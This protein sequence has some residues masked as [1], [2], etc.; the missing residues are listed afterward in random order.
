[1]GVC[2]L[3]IQNSKIPINYTDQYNNIFQKEKINKYS[4]KYLYTRAIA[5]VIIFPPKA[6]WL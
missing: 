1:M 6:F 5:D 2:G 3:F 4:A